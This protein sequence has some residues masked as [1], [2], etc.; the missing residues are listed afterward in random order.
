MGRHSSDP[1]R[2]GRIDP[3]KGKQRCHAPRSVSGEVT[4]TGDGNPP[5][6]SVRWDRPGADAN[7]SGWSGAGGNQGGHDTTPEGREAPMG[8]NPM[9]AVS[10]RRE[11]P[12]LEGGDSPHPVGGEGQ[13]QSAKG[14]E[15]D[16]GTSQ[17]QHQPEHVAGGN[18]NNNSATKDGRIRAWITDADHINNDNFTVIYIGNGDCVLKC[19]IRESVVSCPVD[20]VIR[21]DC[22]DGTCGCVHY[23]AGCVTQL[24]PCRVFC[25]LLLRGDTDPDWQ[26]ILKGVVFGFNVINPSCR[27]DYD[28]KHRTIKNSQ[29]RDIIQKKL[30]SEIDSGCIAVVDSRPT[31]VHDIFCIPKDGGGGRS[32]VDCSEPEGESVNNFTDQVSVKFNYHSVD[33]V[34]DAM[35][36]GDFLATVDIKD[37]Y[38]AVSI[39]PRDRE[40]QG[41]HWDFD[42]DSSSG[43]TY[44][45]DNR[46]CMGISSSPYVF[47]KISDFIV[48]C[49]IREGIDRIIN[50]L[51]DFCIIG[52]D[53]ESASRSQRG[54][55]AIIRRLGFYVSFNKVASPARITRFLGINID[56][57]CLEMSLPEDKLGKLMSVLE[58]VNDRKKITRREMERLGGLLAHCS[59]VI[60]GGRTFC[61][62]IYDAMQGVREPHYKI[63]LN[64]GF[65]E[66]LAWWREFARE[67]NGKARILGRF[68][69]CVSTYSD[70]SNWGYGATHG[71]DWMV[72]AFDPD[73]DENVRRGAGHHHHP[74]D[75]RCAM[76]HINVR[77]MWAA[78]S[79]AVRWGHLW[80][81]SVVVMVTDSTTVRGALNTGRSRCPE[82]MYFVRRLFWLACKHNFEFSAVYIRSGDNVVCDALSRLG[83]AGSCDRIRDVDKVSSMCCSQIF[84]AGNFCISR[85]SRTENREA[86][87][88][89]P[90]VCAKLHH[91]KGHAGAQISGVCE[92][93]R[94]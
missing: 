23:I 65:R 80:K 89:E 82:I 35:E 6:L 1:D 9:R 19:S 20:I 43:C 38:R 54:V 44:M 79:A 32:I 30:A 3:G 48:R 70:A 47:S 25:E 57:T 34:A 78:Y 39:N 33:D 37:A 29:D 94:R 42:P 91:H 88:P 85:D 16:A 61:R 8:G 18:V 63:R 15:T 17:T 74:P 72:G 22:I 28:A 56:T 55:I 68:A 21:Y 31:C 49:A 67:F 36:R 24:R 71:S 83:E 77:E 86:A 69:T 58:E 40:R 14:L 11:N 13:S 62:R 5:P 27:A 50:Y 93:L 73:V 75:V 41:L 4:C 46:L 92:G 2:A 53:F 81:D 26:Y 66:D 12:D 59:K 64:K 7:T 10:V 52:R 60:R 76:A 45:K 87:V 84:T 51:D 90:L